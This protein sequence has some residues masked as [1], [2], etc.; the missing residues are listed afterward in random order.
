M[1][2]NVAVCG[3][4]EWIERE[5]TDAWSFFG[6]DLHH[7]STG[8]RWDLD[9]DEWDVDW[10]EW[11]PWPEDTIEAA[12]GW[13]SFTLRWAEDYLG[14]PME[15]RTAV[16]TDLMDAF[17]EMRALQEEYGDEFETLM[18][19]EEPSNLDTMVSNWWLRSP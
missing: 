7:L 14:Y 12:W 2:S 1:Q 3:V 13:Y 5:V 9:P 6:P 16:S 8:F 4:V 17:Y 19:R 18:L 11:D 10:P 15:C